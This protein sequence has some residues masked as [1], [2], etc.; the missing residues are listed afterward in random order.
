[1]TRTAWYRAR[2]GVFQLLDVSE[3]RFR[4]HGLEYSSVS[5][6]GA[7]V[8]IPFI[9]EPYSEMSWEDYLMDRGG[10]MSL[11][12][13]YEHRV[14]QALEPDD[15]ARQKYLTGIAIL[16]EIFNGEPLGALWIPREMMP[17]HVRWFNS[18]HDSVQGYPANVTTMQ[19]NVLL[20]KS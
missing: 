17:E 5:D 4:N 12:C 2:S 1:M 18:G 14:V 3:V 13:W 19:H 10:D 16:K 9:E 7:R 15:T 20:V 8:V 6:G 11:A